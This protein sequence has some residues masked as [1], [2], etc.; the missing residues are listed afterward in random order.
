M[1]ATTLQVSFHRSAWCPTRCQTSPLYL[2]LLYWPPR[3]RRAK[4]S[5]PS[6]S[7]HLVKL[8]LVIAI[9]DQTQ[10]VRPGD[11]YPPTAAGKD[12]RRQ[13]DEFLAREQQ[14]QQQKDGGLRV[15]ETDQHDGSRVVTASAGG[16]L[17][18]QFTA[19]AAGGA[20]D[21]V[22]IGEVLQAAASDAPVGL[23]DAAAVQAAETRATGLGR[24]VPGGVAAAA[25]KAAETNMR[26]GGGVGDTDEEMV[27]LRDVLGSATAV[28]PANKAVTREDAR[29]VAAAAENAA[30]G[31]GSDVA[32]A[33]AAASE[34]NKGKMTR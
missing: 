12:A 13:R 22:T 31:G 5:V 18:A 10:P 14:P 21:A 8:D 7:S 20:T 16:Q 25:H 27:R 26:L 11:V 23:A 2:L 4:L 9:N 6:C 15:T 34:M 29:K 3:A 28:L 33:V 17:I 19:P 1:C 30:G 24:V 32:D